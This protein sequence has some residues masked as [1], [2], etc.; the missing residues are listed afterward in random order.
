MESKTFLDVFNL[1]IETRSADY[2]YS[3]L[4]IDLQFISFLQDD[5]KINPEDVY[6]E[7]KN[8]IDNLPKMKTMNDNIYKYPN[9]F[10]DYVYLFSP[11]LKSTVFPYLIKAPKNIEYNQGIIPKGI[12]EFNILK[13]WFKDSKH[14][15][16]I[17]IQLRDIITRIPITIT[18]PIASLVFFDYVEDIKDFGITP[19]TIKKLSHVLCDE[20]IFNKNEQVI[21]NSF[22]YRNVFGEIIHLINEINEEDKEAFISNFLLEE[23][24]KPQQS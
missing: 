16:M 8:T 24:L 2:N 1:Y 9:K 17:I 18:S 13:V 11:P 21:I 3:Q 20:N 10:K 5:L 6:L 12:R 7:L 14:G 4:K 19:N 23:E 22:T 15:R